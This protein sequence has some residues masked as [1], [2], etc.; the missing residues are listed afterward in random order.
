MDNDYY[1]PYG[2]KLGK[3]HTGFMSHEELMVL[4][5]S[6]VSPIAFLDVVEDFL[7][8][9]HT[10]FEQKQINEEGEFAFFKRPNSGNVAA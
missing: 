3:L 9:A 6:F 1:G 5:Q 7:K 4:A 2:T 10:V 8:R